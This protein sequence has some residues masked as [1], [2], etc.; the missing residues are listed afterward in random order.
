MDNQKSREV[1][2]PVLFHPKGDSSP[3]YDIRGK[4]D[5]GAMVSCMQTSM[6]SKIGLSQKDL[7]S[8]SAIIRGM[9]GAGLQN[10]GFLDISVT[11]NDITAKSRFYVTKQ[12]CAFILGLGFCKQFKLVTVAPVCIQQ[13]ISMEPCHLRLYTSLKN[14][15]L[16]MTVFKR[17]GRNTYQLEGK[18]VTLWRT[19]SRSSQRPL[20]V[21]LAS[22]KVRSHQK[23]N[24]FSYHPVLYRKASCHN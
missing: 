5:T 9:Y 3:S 4:V 24:Q 12:E 10:W 8:S 1:F 15:R 6:L 20:M 7:R 17:S 14:Q 18:Q 21:R 22:L 11:C 2:P 16:T 13:S 19:L 23:Q